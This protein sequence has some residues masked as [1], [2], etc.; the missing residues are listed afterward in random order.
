M[1]S[2]RSAFNRMAWVVGRRGAS[3]LVLGAVFGI[4]GVLL[5]LHAAENGV[6]VPRTMAVIAAIAPLGTWGWAWIVAA[7]LS[8]IQALLPTKDSRLSF[9]LL[10]FLSAVWAAGYIAG[11]VVMEP[12]RDIRGWLS[13]GLW[14][15]VLLLTLILSGWKEDPRRYRRDYDF[16]GK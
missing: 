15:S 5:L 8:A 7:A 16:G 2:L 12:P 9:S 11:W 14:V 3:L 13:G 1:N 4:Y 10:S 6:E